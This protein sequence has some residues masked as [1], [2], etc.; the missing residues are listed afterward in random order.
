MFASSVVIGAILFC[1]GLLTGYLICLKDNN[2]EKSDE[3]LKSDS[4]FE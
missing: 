4:I 2:N 1:A 3:G